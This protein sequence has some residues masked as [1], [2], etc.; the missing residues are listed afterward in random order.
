MIQSSIPQQVQ[1]AADE[2][3]RLE[4]SLQPPEAAPETPQA[5]S[6]TPEPTP[7]PRAPAPPA[8]TQVKAEEDWRQRYLTLQGMFNAEVPRLNHQIKELTAQVHARPAVPSE[9]A[10]PAL[11]TAPPPQLVTDKDVETFGSDLVDLIKRQS[12]D[13]VSAERARMGEITARLESENADLKKQL[14]GVVERQGATTRQVYMSEVFQLVPDVDAINVDANFISWLAQVD[15]LSGLTRQSYL[16]NA[17]EQFDAH[18]T[19]NLFNAYKAANGSAGAPSAPHADTAHE[20]LRRQVAPDTRKGADAPSGE[21]ESTRIWR[22]ADIERFY[23]DVTKGFY[24]S[25]PAEL[26]RLETEIDLAVATG[27][28]K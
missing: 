1:D 14:G 17:W 22:K 27:R 4:K 23:T 9:P 28:V 6:G 18:R 16:N 21:G 24:A 12:A 3:D 5:A 25:K 7:P 11:H 10:K 13:I 15:P 20:E 2:A 19:A 26:K 8:P